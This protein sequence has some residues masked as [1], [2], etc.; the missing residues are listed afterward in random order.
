MRG[1]DE[2]A[3]EDRLDSERD[4]FDSYKYS[5]TWDFLVSITSRS[6]VWRWMW[7]VL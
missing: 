7:I 4:Q 3:I 2:T 5:G 6:R 1:D